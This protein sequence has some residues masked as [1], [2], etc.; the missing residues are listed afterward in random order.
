MKTVKLN[1]LT[2][3]NNFKR[4]RTKIRSYTKVR[5]NKKVQFSIKKKNVKVITD[6]KYFVFINFG[7]YT[8]Y[9][10]CLSQNTCINLLA[11]TWLLFSLRHN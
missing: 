5:E 8:R 10:M 9:E 6:T 3:L 7:R 4:N 2:I 1:I 11:L